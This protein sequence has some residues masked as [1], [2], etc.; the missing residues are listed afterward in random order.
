M[1]A[2]YYAD[3]PQRGSSRIIFL[4][5]VYVLLGVLALAF[6]SAT[7][8]AAVVTL[9]VVLLVAGVAEIIY[10]IQGRKKGQLWPHLAFGCLALIC[11]GLILANPIENTLGFTLIAGFLLIAS[12]LAK[13]IGAFTERSSGWGWYAANGIISIILGA[14]VLRAFP[15]SAFWTIGVFVGVDLLVAGA[16]LV[17]LGTSAKRAKRELVGQM[18]STLNPEPENRET[19]REDRPLH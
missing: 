14:M 2:I 5:C 16:T 3:S 13:T 11:G 19:H 9:G 15:V 17:G 10:A 12:G 8:L 7:T 1:N 18:Y 4:G 6:A